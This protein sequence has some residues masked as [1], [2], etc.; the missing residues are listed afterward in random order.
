[1]QGYVWREASA[2]DHVCVPP[3]TRQQAADDN[4]AAP[5]RFARALAS[6]VCM[7]GYVWRE[8]SPNDH[9]CVV[10][11]TRADTALENQLGM[12]RRAK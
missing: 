12:S 9:V 5:R 7:S 1:L 6:D 4:A 8:A 2:A 3:A 10:P 11:S